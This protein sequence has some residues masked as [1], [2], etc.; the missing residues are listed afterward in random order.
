MQA[1]NYSGPKIWNS[2]PEYVKKEPR[3]VLSILDD[4]ELIPY[5]AFCRGIKSFALSD[6]DFI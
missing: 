4:S 3:N 5:K 6:I 1:L 2:L